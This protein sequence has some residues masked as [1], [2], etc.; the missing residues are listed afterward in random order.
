[1]AEY[2]GTEGV[3]EI[4]DSPIAVAE[5]TLKVTRGVASH[6][7]SGKHSDLKLPGKVDVTGTIKRIMIDG[8][9]LGKVVGDTEETGEA[10]ALHAGLAIPGAGAELV[11]DMTATDSKSSLIKFTALTSAVTAVGKAILYGTDIND[12]K[13]TEVVTIP[14]LGI[15][16]TTTGKKIFKTLTHVVTFDYVQTAGSTMKVDAVVGASGIVVGEAK[17]FKIK[18]K[19]TSGSN[20]V[21]V[22]AD[23]CFL[24]DGEFAFSDADTIM[25]DTLSFTMKDPDADLKV[26][27]V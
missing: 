25:S 5:F 19:A 20:H 21:Y 12:N 16:E 6:G 1:M 26:E 14:K 13:L 24:T 22:T 18:G 10:A 3:L 4:A 17:I 15:N 8:T 27:Y 7:R 23:N 2:T 9:M 11:T